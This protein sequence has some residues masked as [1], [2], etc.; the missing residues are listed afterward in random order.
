MSTKQRYGNA[1]WDALCALSNEWSPRIHTFVTVGEV[2]KK[3]GV[4]KPT[5]Y[6]YLSALY[7]TGHASKMKM[8]NNWVFRLL[9]PA[10][11]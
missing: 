8:G 7:E 5:A 9:S 10:Q 2:A 6:K 1:V 11:D 3:A 4:T